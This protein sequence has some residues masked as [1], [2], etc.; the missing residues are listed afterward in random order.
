M[1]MRPHIST[2]AFVVVLLLAVIGCGSPEE[3]KAK[4]LAQAHDYIQDGNLPKARVALRNV[5][6]I[7][8]KDPEAYFV[9][10][11]VEEKEKNWRNAFGNYQRTIE[12][13]P[14]HQ[15]ALIKLAKFY[16]EARAMDKVLEMTE[17]V[18]ANTPG[19][20]EA[21][22]LKIAVQAVK[23][24][25]SEATLAAEALARSTRPIPMPRRSWRHCIWLK[26][27]AVK[28][29]RL[30]NA[31]SRPI[32]ATLCCWTPSPR[33]CSGWTSLNRPRKS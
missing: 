3:K 6:K 27:D 19:Q 26:A 29:S 31:R 23:G 15:R 10:A 22:A 13:K 33:P 20:V 7:D 28:S 11:E 14:D 2:A 25:L 4:Y 18:L 30:C 8:P 9:F 5:L 21:E 17:K 16:L 32:P 12:L 1:S 24:N